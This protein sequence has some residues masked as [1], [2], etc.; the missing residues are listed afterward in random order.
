[1]SEACIPAD[2]DIKESGVEETCVIYLI[3][4]EIVDGYGKGFRAIISTMPKMKVLL[5]VS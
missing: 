2:G 4:T 3:G 1:M 5:S